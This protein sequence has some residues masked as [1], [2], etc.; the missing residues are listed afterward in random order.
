VPIRRSL[1][2]LAALILTAASCGGGG[3]GATTSGS[4]AGAS[5]TPAASSNGGD[6]AKLAG[7]SG[8]VQDHGTAMVSRASV[9]LAAGDFFFEPTCLTASSP[10]TITVT[11]MN[12]G[13][14]LH[15]FTVEELGI[16]KDVPVGGSVTVK[17]KLPGSGSLPFL[18]KYH[19]A[20]GMQGAFIL[21]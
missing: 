10:A 3:G 4:P 2:G 7:L 14:A 17:V 1:A 12:T 5:P 9:E 16:D 13:S 11:V 8:T 15:N 20:S 18:C 6:C 19:S 21:G